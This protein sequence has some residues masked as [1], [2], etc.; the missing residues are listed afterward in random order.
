MKSKKVGVVPI[1]M[2]FDVVFDLDD[3]VADNLSMILN[4]KKNVTKN[5]KVSRAISWPEVAC[6]VVSYQS[7]YRAIKAALPNFLADVNDKLEKNKG[8][9]VDCTVDIP[10][11]IS[12]NRKFLSPKDYSEDGL[13]V[14]T[15][16]EEEDVAEA[17]LYAEKF[18]QKPSAFIEDI[19]RTFDELNSKKVTVM[20]EEEFYVS[21]AEPELTRDGAEYYPGEVVDQG[22]NS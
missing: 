10:E 21:I 16:F 2:N 17:E 19:V 1:R 15:V 4:G 13:I 14:Y 12:V 6:H 20:S 9:H 18:N 8:S 22:D 5:G 7:L 11:N 3:L